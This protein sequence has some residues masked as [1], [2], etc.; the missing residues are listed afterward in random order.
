MR[1]EVHILVNCPITTFLK[2][3]QLSALIDSLLVITR[4]TLKLE[5]MNNRVSVGKANEIHEVL[6]S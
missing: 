1:G 3:K 5:M 4:C 6:N 2:E